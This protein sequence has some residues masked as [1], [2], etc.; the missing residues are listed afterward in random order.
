MPGLGQQSELAA[1]IPDAPTPRQQAQ[2]QAPNPVQNGVHTGVDVFLTLQ[3]KSLV[4][5]DLATTEGPLSPWDKLKLGANNT[6]SLSSVGA[7]LIGSAYGQAVNSPSVGAGMGCLRPTL[8]G[9]YGSRG[10]LQLFW[11][12]RDCLRDS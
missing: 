1:A 10:F 4:F 8:R 6:V 5:P 9:G 3:K 12:L 2:P 7:V 11:H